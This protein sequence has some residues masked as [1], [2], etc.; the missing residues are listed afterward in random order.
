VKEV[1]K[2]ENMSPQSIRQAIKWASDEGWNP[3]PYDGE[4]FYACD[5]YGFFIGKLNGEPIGCISAVKYQGGFGFVGLYIVRLE[6]RGKGYGMALWN[7]A[8]EYLAGCNA[9]LDGVVAQQENYKRSGFVLAHRNIRYE[10]NDKP[11]EIAVHKN[12][13]SIEDTSFNELVKYDKR[14]FLFSRDVFLHKWIEQPNAKCFLYMEEGSI[15]GYGVIRQCGSGYKIGPLFS[16]TADIAEALFLSLV[17]TASGGSVFLDVPEVNPDAISLA[18]KYHM[19]KVFETARMYTKG[20]PGLPLRNIYGI[21][22][23]ELG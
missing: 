2:I 22:T 4:C 17:G 11:N 8:M 14:H 16:E 12:V 20:D 15:K 13:V 7:K 5:P 18:E 1:Y 21:T 3:G 6:Y 19:K 10:L 9:A 23:F